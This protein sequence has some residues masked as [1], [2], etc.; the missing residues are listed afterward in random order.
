MGI[1]NQGTTQIRRI[2]RQLN[3]GKDND[4]RPQRRDRYELEEKGEIRNMRSEFNDI[5]TESRDYYKESRTIS[6]KR[7]D[8]CHSVN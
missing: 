7:Y 3:L 4:Y 1:R 2:S 6:P 5:P 8:R